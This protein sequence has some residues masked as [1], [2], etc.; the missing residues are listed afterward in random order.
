MKLTGK[1][2]SRWDWCAAGAMAV[3]V[4]VIFHTFIFSDA[5]IFGTDMVPMGYMMRQ[6]VADG[7]R[8]D[9]HLP[10]WNP[11]ILCGLPVVDAMHGDLFYPASLLYLV[12]PLAKALGYKIVLHVWLA[13]LAMYVL[14]RV[15]RLTRRAALVGGI[16]YMVAPYFL[17]LV[18]AGHD[19]KMFV[20]ALFPLCVAGLEMLLQR[21][22]YIWGVIFGVL[23]G[24]LFLTTHPQ[25]TYFAIWGLTIYFLFK[26]PR[27]ISAKQLRRSLLLVAVA[28]VLGVGLGC[29]QFLPT[30]YYTTNF[31]PRTGGVTFEFA[32]SW[33]LHPEEIVSLLLPAFVGYDVGQAGSYWGR[34]PFKLNTESPG[35]LVLLLALGAIALVWRRR[36]AWP[37][38]FLFVFCPL[39]ALG[40]HT[41]LLKIA[42]HAIP[43]AK[44]L[45]APSIIMF[46][47]SCSSSVLAAMLVD[48][49]LARQLTPGLKKII[50]GLGIFLVVVALVFTVGRGA[51]LGAW[52]GIFGKLAAENLAA[53]ERSGGALVRDALLVALTGGVVLGVAA[54][55]Y[56]ARQKGNL[57][58][59]LCLA[60]V[61]VTSLIHS[62][63]FITY[64]DNQSALRNWLKPDQA[65]RYLM[66]DKDL[67][68]VL[69]VTGSSFYNRN[70]LPI[71]GLQTANGFYDNRVRFYE[72]LTGAGQEN[73]VNPNILRL[74]NVKYVVTN[75]RVDHPALSLDRSF[76]Q[77]MVYR[78]R[79]YLPRAFMVHNAVVAESDSAA[80]EII[81]GQGFDPASTVVLAEGEPLSGG[82]PGG[83]SA[84]IETYTPGRVVVRTVSRSP[85]YLFFSENYLPY[86]KA[87][88]DGRPA[89]LVRADV[90]MR[91]VYLE[92]GDHVVEMKYTSRWYVIGLWIFVASCVAV[93]ASV[94]VWFRKGL[95]RGKR[96]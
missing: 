47:F 12:M 33:S 6:V 93:A 95:P 54:S 81:M 60:G 35:P 41:P 14:L 83:E 78:N 76:G 90:A 17:S 64:V 25:M 45:R 3:L 91:A 19:G 9:H 27:L 42:F 20:T 65:I 63:R 96:A 68:R 44:F 40:A 31:S 52:Q 88:V 84:T 21:L 77:V 56:R 73:L 46:M 29:V 80:L 32:S 11:Y 86:W 51:F 89:P 23:L 43:G 53:A 85:G 5:M 92:P 58:L 61:L 94:A 34:N 36:E 22:R 49:L 16:A 39:Y 37:W 48:C 57:L 82:A 87:R 74:T 69:P 59:G 75:S 71:F 70:Y 55:R 50:A 67:F 72:T 28:L 10:A 79:G 62:A 8:A 38:I 13:G 4:V 2:V 15:L 26:V 1:H 18:Y 7:W 30:Y 24:L 66:E